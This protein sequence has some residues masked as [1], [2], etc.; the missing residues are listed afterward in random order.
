MNSFCPSA[1]FD[2]L[3]GTDGGQNGR[4]SANIEEKYNKKQSNNSEICGFRDFCER[5][6]NIQLPTLN[7]K[8]SEFHT[9]SSELP[10]RTAR[11]NRRGG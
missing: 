3:G 8:C 10:S 9:P 1:V 11:T 5:Y 6:T 4:K 2:Y 7:L